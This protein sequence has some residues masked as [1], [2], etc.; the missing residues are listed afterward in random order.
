M[1]FFTILS[2]LLFGINTLAQ[3]NSKFIEDFNDNSNN[4]NIE[5][6]KDAS[7][8]VLNGVFYL[9]HYKN[10]ASWRFWK[11]FIFET[12]K[13][14]NI[15][16]KLKQT[17]GAEDGG[18]GIVWGSNGWKNSYHFT[19]SSNGEF[20]IWGYKNEEFFEWK[21]WS[22]FSKIKPFGEYNTLSIKKLMGNMYFYI[23][24][25]LAYNHRFE[26]FFGSFFGFVVGKETNVIVDNFTLEYPKKQIDIA[27]DL[28]Q[29]YKKKNLG[30]SINSM[31]SEI[32]P[33][34]SPDGKT[35]YVARQNHPENYGSQKLYDVWYAEKK[36]D[37]SWTSM[38]RMGKPINNEGDNLV[39]SVS[40]DGNTLLLEGLYSSTGAYVSDQGISVSN[41]TLNGWTIPK[42]VLIDN[43]YNNNEFESYCPT[44]DKKVLIMSVQRN[45]SYGNKDLYVSFLKQNGNYSEPVNMGKDLNTYLNEGTPFIA[46]DNKTL[47][48]YSYAF[49]G[50]GSAD[51]FVTKRLDE[52]W[53]KWS[54]PKNLG[55]TVNSSDWDTYYSV[56]AKGD[57]AY[58]VSTKGSYGN[59]D[60]FEIKM[61]EDSKPETVVLIFGKVFNKKT[62]K[63]IGV[64][65]VYEDLKTGKIA[66]SARSNPRTGSYKIILPYGKNYS[67]RAEAD[68]FIAINE[69]IDLLKIGKY[70]EKKKNLFL[71]P[72]EVGQTVGLQTIQFTRSKSELTESSYPELDRF[73]NLMKKYPKMEIEL[74]GHTDTRGKPELLLLLSKNRVKAVKD[75]LIKKGI[76]SKRITGKGYGGTKPLGTGYD[77]IE[78]K[79]RRVEFKISKM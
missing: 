78:I 69:E 52:T 39:I 21:K 41:R 77:E 34:I 54:K 47:Y 27:G 72:I 68:D 12:D 9:N 29:K 18:Y 63:P 13:T 17:S 28:N 15:D 14:F 36:S 44:A 30:K 23:N 64:D 60:I 79:N 48:F 55:P 74:S 19:I 37:G 67:F 70:L 56:S 49:P 65:I 57:Y 7:S 20:A 31:Y 1:R 25:S 35:L 8:K 26:P 5:N 16:V 32:A 73:V 33:I 71:V 62:N 75:Y 38:K 40:P 4:W 76:N 24:G 46:S 58:L 42:K 66:G 61:S 10:S 11:E 50:Y 2:I 45:D 3:N 53:T 22:A 6:S 51:I 59:E 43:F